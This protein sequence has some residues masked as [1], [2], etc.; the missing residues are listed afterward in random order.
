M[1][2]KNKKI[3]LFIFKDIIFD[4][5]IKL[6]LFQIYNIIVINFILL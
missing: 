6:I 2:L 4:K 3:L 5:K 1:I